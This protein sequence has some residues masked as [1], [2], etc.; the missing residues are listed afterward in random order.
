MSINQAKY[1]KLSTKPWTGNI[2]TD[3]VAS[4]TI[5][6][7]AGGSVTLTEEDGDLLLNGQPIPT[8]GGGVTSITSAPGGNIT[9][10]PTIG[11]GDVTLSYTNPSH[12]QTLTGT[13]GA[14]SVTSTGPNAFSVGLQNVTSY[15]SSFSINPANS[16][17]FTATGTRGDVTVSSYANIGQAVLSVNIP[18]VNGGFSFT[19]IDVSSLTAGLYFVENRFDANEPNPLVFQYQCGTIMRKYAAGVYVNLNHWPINTGDYLKIVGSFVATENIVNVDTLIPPWQIYP[20]T[21]SFYRIF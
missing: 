14:I 9:V 15:I 1:I 16:L 20:M 13:P 19:D 4:L 6:D 2:I 3:P 5:V 8:S 17:Q 21:V 18:D 7:A 12:I 10:T 11:T